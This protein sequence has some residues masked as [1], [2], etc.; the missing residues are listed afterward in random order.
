[1]KI[2]LCCLLLLFSSYIKAQHPFGPSEGG[3]PE[4]AVYIELLGGAIWPLMSF[5]DT[6][7]DNE[8][9][10]LFIR[11]NSGMAVRFEKKGV[12]SVGALVS[13]R[14]QG[15]MFPDRSKLLLK[16]NYLNFYMPIEKDWCLSR[17]RKN[18]GPSIVFFAGPY[19]AYFLGGSVKD[20]QHDLT[21]SS[22]Q[23]NQ[24]DVG[25]EAG[26]GFRI[27]TFSIEKRSN[28]YLKFSYYY[29]FMNTHP[30]DI[31]DYSDDQLNSY[32]LSKTGTRLNQGFRLTLSY[33]IALG[34]HNIQ[35]FSAGGDGK[36]TYKKFIVF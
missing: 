34:K 27:P 23:I 21:L 4:H 16:S 6:Q 8:V 18:S 14:E 22:E 11:Q 2:L 20:Q 26:L 35:T 3:K 30:V 33:E 32:L 9:H 36:R 15:V 13:Y 5:N 1:M 24:W 10:Q 29:G 12:L 28:L 17:L 7:F 31:P 25:A 19:A